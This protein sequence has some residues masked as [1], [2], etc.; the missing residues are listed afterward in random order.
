MN[1][2]N[3]PK[4]PLRL[5]VLLSGNGSNLQA[6]IDAIENKQLPG[7]EIALVVSNHANAYGLQRALKHTLPAIYL[8]WNQPNIGADLSSPAPIYRP[9]PDVPLNSDIRRGRFIEPSA[10]LSAPAENFALQMKKLLSI[11]APER[12]LMSDSEARLTSLLHLF[13][14][15]YIVLAGWMRILSA[16]F[17][18]Q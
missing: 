10:D 11:I 7:V 1:S 4:A 18:A 16:P 14:I 13:Q 2:G 6:L 5:A 9:P 17:L 8:P 12:G 15:D 3:I